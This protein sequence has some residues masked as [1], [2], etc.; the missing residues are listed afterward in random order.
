MKKL[1]LLLCAIFFYT[2]VSAGQVYDNSAEFLAAEGNSC[3]TATDGCNTIKI[4]NGELGIA[5]RMYCEDTYGEEWKEEWSC[6]DDEWEEHRIGFL[7]DNDKNQYQSFQANL[8]EELSDTI[9]SI[10]Q[11]YGDKILNKADFNTP[12]AISKLE[13]TIA[14]FEVAI[15]KLIAKYPAD[16]GMS[17]K[18][19]RLYYILTVAKYELQIMHHRWKQNTGN[20]ISN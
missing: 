18:D 13:K 2:S 6:I 4:W 15:S 1:F 8:G 9:E 17:D 5:S 16:A 12:K 10:I 14:S 7:S 3:S 11:S 20:L 19:T